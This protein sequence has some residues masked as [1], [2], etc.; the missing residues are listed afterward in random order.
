MNKV[1]FISNTANFSKFNRPFML[2]FKEH[3]W[4][5]DYASPGEEYV[6]DCDY[7]YSISI[8]R[9]PFSLKNIKAYFEL[10]KLLTEN[11]YDIIHC[12]TPL[13]GVIGR[14]AAKRFWKKSKIKVIYTAHGFHFYKGASLVN[15]IFYYSVEKWLAKY[16]DII[17]TI[18]EEDFNRAQHFHNKKLSIYKIDGVGVNLQKFFPIQSEEEKKLLR[19]NKNF[20]MKDFILLYTAEFIPRKNHKLIFDI[21]PNLKKNIPELKVIFC[22]KGKLL[23]YYKSFSANNNM[24]YI[25][26]TGYTKDVADYCRISD[27]LVMPSFQEGLPMGMIEAIATGLPVVA[28][29]IRGHCDVIENNVNGFLI[30]LDKKEE[31]FNSIIKLYN[32]PELRKKMGNE[33]IQKA[34]K[35]SVDLAVTNMAKIY[36]KLM[37]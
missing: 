6:N 2:W 32:S 33:N 4:Q 8:A 18:N 31:F 11:Q 35:Y 26:F 3:N 20:T 9:S 29:N 36:E 23:E 37:R 5:V 24:D 15:W 25:T 30:N 10:K 13:G 17:V 28:S 34:K 21:L 14:L 12:H 22:G 7:Q 16:T 19:Q 1:L 27:L